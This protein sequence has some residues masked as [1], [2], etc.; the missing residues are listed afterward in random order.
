VIT[1]QDY[2]RPI[3]FN[4]S[5]TAGFM[6]KMPNS[7]HYEVWHEEDRMCGDGD[8]FNIGIDEAFFDEI[9][10]CRAELSMGAII[11]IAAAVV[12]IVGIGIVLVLALVARRQS[13]RGHLETL[14]TTELARSADYL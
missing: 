11:A 10:L 8:G 3:F 7:G 4:A 14:D 5:T 13:K 12:G 6:V 9:S 1:G 2:R